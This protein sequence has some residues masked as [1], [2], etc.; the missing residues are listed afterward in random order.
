MKSPL[1]TSPFDYLGRALEKQK[2][3]D[4]IRTRGT[5][6]IPDA[7]RDVQ[8][9]SADGG[10]LVTWKLPEIHSPIAGWR[11]YLN[12][13]SNLAVQLRDKGTRQAFVPL[14]SGASP[15]SVNVMVSAMS[16]LGRESAKVIKSAAPL[17]Q[18]LTT[19]VPTAPPGYLSEG[20]GGK[21]RRLTR[22][23][24]QQQYT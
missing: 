22:F 9:Q 15:I 20:S 5:L 8:V 3:R 13:E 4:Q 1:K 11:I 6:S 10:I 18:A 14:S 21:D 7:P 23:N 2:A 12:T 17:A 19:T 24:G 16:E